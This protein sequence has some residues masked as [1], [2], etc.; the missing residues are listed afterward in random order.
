M[1]VEYVVLSVT[2]LL[3]T[4]CTF[5]IVTLEYRPT[6]LSNRKAKL[7]S[8]AACIIGIYFVIMGCVFIVLSNTPI[9]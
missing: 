3:F 5:P 4:F 1:I 6:K 9:N 7:Y 8:T 2:S